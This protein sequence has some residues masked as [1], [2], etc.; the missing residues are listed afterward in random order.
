MSKSPKMV[1]EGAKLGKQA[2]LSPDNNDRGIHTRTYE[3][4][5]FVRKCLILSIFTHL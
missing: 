2:V 3:K 4:S 5:N 1:L